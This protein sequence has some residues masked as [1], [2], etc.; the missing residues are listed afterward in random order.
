[1]NKRAS[2]AGYGEK[3]QP[4]NQGAQ[5][6]LDAQEGKDLA[7][8]GPK[9]L[10]AATQPALESAQISSGMGTAEG[11]QGLGYWNSTIPLEQQYQEQLSQRNQA[12]WNALAQIPKDL[13]AFA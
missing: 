13:T 6:Q 5:T 9:S 11:S 7:Q 1:M 3:S 8:V 4:V 2:A 12:M 10:V